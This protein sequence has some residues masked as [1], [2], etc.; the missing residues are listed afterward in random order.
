MTKATFGQL[1]KILTSLTTARAA[2]HRVLKSNVWSVLLFGCDAWT[3][4]K[5]RRRRFEATKMWFYI[6]MIKVPWT[7]RRTNQEAMQIVGVT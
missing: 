3:I 4:S 5:E 2:R 6:R 7:A 1:R